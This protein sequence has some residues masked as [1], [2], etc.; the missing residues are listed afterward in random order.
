MVANGT[1]IIISET[2][3]LLPAQRKAKWEGAYFFLWGQI[4]HQVLFLLHWEDNR[5][6]KD[7]NLIKNIP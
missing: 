3:L 5:Q 6:I 2:V 7:G 4:R 1:E